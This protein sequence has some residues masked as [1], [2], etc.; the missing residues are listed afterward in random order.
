MKF[1]PKFVL[2]GGIIFWGALLPS[3]F[4]KEI[5]GVCHHGTCFEPAFL[6]QGQTLK[7]RSYATK[8]FWGLTVYDAA[9]YLPRDFNDPGG[10]LGPVPKKLVLRYHRNISGDDIRRAS[11]HC[12]ESNPDLDLARLRDRI[13]QIHEAYRDVK[14][15][16]QYALVFVPG[17]GTQLYLNGSFVTEIP[18]EDFQ[19][20]YFGI[21]LSENPISHKLRKDLLDLGKGD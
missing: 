13:E 14:A 18:G 19:K 8:R 12:L 1:V 10:V 21:W 7:L 20:A 5:P 3:A 2:L 9:L 6:S 17:K 11:W 15:H 4:P 16:D